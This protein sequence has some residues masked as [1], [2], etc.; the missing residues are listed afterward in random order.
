MTADL[1]CGSEVF[2]PFRLLL[3]SSIDHTSQIHFFLSDLLPRVLA[4]GEDHLDPL[5]DFL[6]ARRQTRMMKANHF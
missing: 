4:D 6:A 5:G 2:L 1:S 3:L